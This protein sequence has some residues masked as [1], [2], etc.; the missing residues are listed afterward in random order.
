MHFCKQLPPEGHPDSSN[1]NQAVSLFIIPIFPPG[2]KYFR[3]L[4]EKE[5]LLYCHFAE[6]E[7]NLKNVLWQSFCLPIDIE[8]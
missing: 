4:L 7:V 3:Q 8:R 6:K 1:A 2:G 5:M